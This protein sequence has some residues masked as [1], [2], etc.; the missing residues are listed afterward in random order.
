M[1]DVYRLPPAFS[2]APQ[3]TIAFKANV[4]YTITVD[5]AITRKPTTG[6]ACTSDLFYEECEGGNRVTGS[7]GL[8][9]S[10]NGGQT[11]GSFGIL[12]RGTRPYSSAHHYTFMFTTTGAIDGRVRAAPGYSLDK[13]PNVSYTGG[14]TITVIAGAA[15]PGTAPGTTSATTTS[16]TPPGGCVAP[17]TRA[18]G[19]AHRRLAINE[20]RVVK[21]TPSVE[22]HKAGKA[23]GCW[24]VAV[25]DTVLKQGDEISCDPDGEIVL[26][27]ADNSTVTVRNTTQLKIASFFTEGGII[28]TEILLK[29]GEVAAEVNKSEATKSDFKIK[30]PTDTASV[31][32]TKFTV[33][34]DPVAKVSITSVKAGTVE[35]DPKKA[36][37]ATAAVPA[38]K[39]IEVTGSSASAV[40]V[41]GKA[42]TPPGAVSRSKA[43]SLALKQLARN[44][45]RCKIAIVAYTLKPVSRGWQASFRVNGKT[46]SG[47][48]V[49]TVSGLAGKVT[50]LN[51]L[52]KRIASGCR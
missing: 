37:L 16:S 51:A 27:F 7:S 48:A 41:I 30:T 17:P 19:S 14:F 20:V 11:Y 44:D 32:G 23:E 33:S 50:P 12:A 52:A 35:V 1:S 22:F 6:M 43:R 5:G 15:P 34:Y 45:E 8:M 36:G 10:T 13:E 40:V 46:V 18:P 47:W 39:E 28:K 38:G 3:A 29:M 42:G 21:V 4:P 24:E 26:A 9:M 2:T 31:R 49:F 25:K